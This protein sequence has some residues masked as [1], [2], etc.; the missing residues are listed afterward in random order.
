MDPG[1]IYIYI[2]IAHSDLVTCPVAMLE[3]YMK[4]GQVGNSPELP[5]FRGIV[6]T[7]LGEQLRKIGGISYTFLLLTLCMHWG[8]GW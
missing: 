2:V 8:W 5:L 3:H 7:K 1:Y 6:H 4:L